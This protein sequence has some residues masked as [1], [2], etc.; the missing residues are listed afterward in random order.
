MAGAAPDVLVLGGGLAG[1]AAALKAAESGRSVTLLRRGPGASALS[2]GAIDV[3]P[4]PDHR[5]GALPPKRHSVAECVLALAAKR[6]GHP[7]AAL[8]PSGRERMAEALAFVLGRLAEAGLPHAPFDPGRPGHAVVG[9]T[10]AMRRVATAQAGQVFGESAD[11]S[12][13]R[14]GVVSLRRHPVLQGDLIRAG[15]RRMV[16]ETVAVSVEWPEDDDAPFLLPVE[17]GRRLDDA[18]ARGRFVAEVR[19]A[20]EG[21]KLSHL[22]LPPVAGFDRPGEVNEALC[23]ATG[24]EVVESLGG[25]ASLAGHRLEGAMARALAAAG[26]GV[27]SVRTAEAS[28][29]RVAGAGAIVLA[30]GRFI[31]GGIVRRGRFREP[32]FDLPLHDGLR[33][34]DDDPVE[35]L[36]DRWGFGAHGLFRAGVKVDASLRPLTLE[37][38]PL[39][40]DLFAAGS[41]IGGYDPDGDRCGM[42]VALLTGFLAGEAAALRAAGGEAA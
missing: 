30:T 38:R 2:T 41:V 5:A 20:V 33:R 37:G 35:M 40:D 10:G 23:E 1:V 24:L 25:E 11:L 9:P 17:I 19:A 32:V 13:A 14:V 29:E 26:V 18:E 6:E 31:G 12:A 42:G 28:A 16:A 22:V 34:V 36:T 27:E 3:A 4:D 8:G 39:R 21:K 7:Y 15:L